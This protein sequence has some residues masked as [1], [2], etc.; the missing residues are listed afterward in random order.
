MILGGVRSR[1]MGPGYGAFVVTKNV[2][3]N[4]QLTKSMK[5]SPGIAGKTFIVQGLGQMGY[6]VSKYLIQ[7]GAKLIG[8]SEIDGSLYNPK[9]INL[10]ALN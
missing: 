7:A 9:G 2:L 1:R 8:V 5:L 6:F 4:A 3:E 10:Q